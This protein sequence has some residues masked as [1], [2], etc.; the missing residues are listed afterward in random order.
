M[1]AALFSI[2]R[3]VPSKGVKQLS[4]PLVMKDA[5]LLGSTVNLWRAVNCLACLNFIFPGLLR[6]ITQHFCGL[7]VVFVVAL[8]DYVCWGANLETRL[9]CN[10]CSSRRRAILASASGIL[11]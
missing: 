5:S 2:N 7:T 9:R 3:N 6:P 4:D 1:L 8:N 10:A 11:R